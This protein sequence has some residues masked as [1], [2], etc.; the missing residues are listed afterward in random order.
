M[1]KP[2]LE[3]K[4]RKTQAKKRKENGAESGKRKWQRDE[5]T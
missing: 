2:K 4:K 5:R 1:K 3:N